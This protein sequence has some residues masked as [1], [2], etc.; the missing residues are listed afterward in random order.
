MEKFLDVMEKGMENENMSVFNCLSMGTMDK[1]AKVM[2]AEGKKDYIFRRIEKF[3]IKIKPGTI[4]NFP[5]RNYLQLG[6]VG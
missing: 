2:I 6:Y 5:N 4:Q 1:Y 3:L